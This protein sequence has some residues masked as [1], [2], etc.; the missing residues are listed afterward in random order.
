MLE[1]NV[2][3]VLSFENFKSWISCWENFHTADHIVLGQI[4][5][6]NGKPRFDIYLFSLFIITCH[7]IQLQ[8][9]SN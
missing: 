2:V 5:G 8:F 3:S 6:E 4:G 1:I 7:E 9:N